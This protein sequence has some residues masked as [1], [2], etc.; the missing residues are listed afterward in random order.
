[1]DN[2]IC[3]NDKQLNSLNLKKTGY[4]I[5]GEV[6][7]KALSETGKILEKI[8]WIDGIEVIPEIGFSL[9]PYYG[10]SF[11]WGWDSGNSGYNTSLSV[12]CYIFRDNRIAENLFIPFKEEFIDMFPNGNFEMDVKLDEFL[13]SYNDRLHPNLYSRFCKTALVNSKEILLYKDPETGKISANLADNYAMHD[14][15]LTNLEI[16]KLNE[17]KQRLVFRLFAKDDYL[18]TGYDFKTVMDKSEEVMERFY[19][20]SFERIIKKRY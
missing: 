3:I 19:K 20:T 4:R 2:T 16:K 14:K 15:K 1:M 10:S 18:I 9:R 17:R 13:K 8:I 12:C 5:K 7:D 11:D 6:P